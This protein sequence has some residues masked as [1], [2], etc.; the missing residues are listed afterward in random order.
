MSI[1]SAKVTS[2][3]AVCLSSV[4]VEAW[5]LTPELETIPA[6]ATDQ[7]SNKKPPLNNTT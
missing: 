2:Q 5:N 4:L 6:L 3:K 7:P 1:S